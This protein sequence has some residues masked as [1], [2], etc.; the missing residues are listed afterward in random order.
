MKITNML[1]L[2]FSCWAIL[3]MPASAE[4]QGSVTCEDK[5]ISQDSVQN[6][7]DQIVPPA[8]SRFKLHAN[9]QN[10]V[11]GA[12]MEQFRE[13]TF[14]PQ[15][16]VMVHLPSHP[17]HLQSNLKD[18]LSAI[19][20]EWNNCGC[21][22]R[23]VD[24]NSDLYGQIQCGDVFMSMDGLKPQQGTILKTNF[25]NEQTLMDLRFLHNHQCITIM[26]HRHPITWFVP[27]FQEELMSGRWRC[28]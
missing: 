4:L 10:L 9:D 20:I 28:Y 23:Y 7:I 13:P 6:Q 15:Q 16:A 27:W 19:G 5:T 22:I 11:S 2:L 8:P 26:C 12:A 25:G 24:P 3:S 21:I 18:R 1:G 17:K 14:K